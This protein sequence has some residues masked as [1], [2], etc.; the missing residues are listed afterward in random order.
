MVIFQSTGNLRNKDGECVPP[1]DCDTIP[2]PGTRNLDTDNIQD[3]DNG[4][5]YESLGRSI[6]F[7]CSSG[8]KF[9][10]CGQHCGESCEHLKLPMVCTKRCEGFKILKLFNNC[11]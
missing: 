7:N 10:K 3:Y 1:Q 8:E 9:S 11:Y 5:K 2:K 4:P 6:F